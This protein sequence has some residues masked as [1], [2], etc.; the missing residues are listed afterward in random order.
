MVYT[1]IDG[2]KYK[3]QFL[4]R[5]Y[6][7]IAKALDDPDLIQQVYLNFKRLLIMK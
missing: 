2:K 1:K 7:L 3:P 6:E 4:M 5:E